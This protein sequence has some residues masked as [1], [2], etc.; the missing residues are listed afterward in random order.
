MRKLLFLFMASV[1]VS[2]LSLPLEAQCQQWAMPKHGA[3]GATAPKAEST[4]VFPPMPGPGKK[5]PVGND[6]YLI[7]G[8][9]KKP[10]L[11]MLIM[12]IEVFTKDGKKDTSFEIKADA[13]MP[14]MK[15]AHETRRPAFQ[16]FQE[17]RLPS[18]GQYR[19]ARRLGNK[20]DRLKGWK[21]PFHGELSVRCLEPCWSAFRFSA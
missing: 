19:H 8:F 15:G 1:V 20:A 18:A 10:K 2:L 17:R 21:G 13:G 7:F 11:G 3:G 12:K 4:Q 16:A 14:S 5:V 9:D 6:H